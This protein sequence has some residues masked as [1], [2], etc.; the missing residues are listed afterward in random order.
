MADFF[1]V[2]STICIVVLKSTPADSIKSDIHGKI[3]RSYNER[4]FQKLENSENSINNTYK[5]FF[6]RFKQK[7]LEGLKSE[8]YFLS[9]FLCF[10][11]RNYFKNK[12]NSRPFLLKNSLPG[13]FQVQNSFSKRLK[14]SIL[15]RFSSAFSIRFM[16]KNPVNTY[17]CLIFLFYF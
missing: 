10:Q 11:Y 3:L 7:K 14:I 8:K 1:D 16:P 6:F 4:S 2:K 15:W 5:K 13:Y 12:K 17:L 9:G